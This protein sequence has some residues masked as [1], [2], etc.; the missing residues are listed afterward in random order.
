MIPN[1][2]NDFFESLEVGHASPQ[3][4]QQTLQECLNNEE[5]KRVL[6]RLIYLLH[7]A[8]N[9]GEEEYWNL[10]QSEEK[11]NWEYN[12]ESGMKSWRKIGDTTVYNDFQMTDYWFDPKN[13][14]ELPDAMQ[15][16]RFKIER[17]LKWKY[18]VEKRLRRLKHPQE[19]EEPSPY[20]CKADFVRVVTAMTRVGILRE[21]LQAED[22]ANLFWAGNKVDWSKTQSNIKK[23]EAASSEMYELIKR[24]FELLSESKK[25][26]FET[27]VVEFNSKINAEKLLAKKSQ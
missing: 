13:Y 15:A 12:V 19:F 23:N 20:L 10:I 8:I 9:K 24:L 5:Q 26:E 14:E 16:I 3:F 25:E 21:D 27:H 7:N 22:L 18:D 2:K 1:A 6:R 17:W 4:I 11:L